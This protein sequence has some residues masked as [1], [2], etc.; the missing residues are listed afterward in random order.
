M[1]ARLDIIMSNLLSQ[2]LI[3]SS[4]PSCANVI[5]GE[6]LTVLSCVGLLLLPLFVEELFRLFS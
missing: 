3:S 6:M 4:S 5:G 1:S 2:Y